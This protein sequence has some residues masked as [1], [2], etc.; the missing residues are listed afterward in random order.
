M[1]LTSA[2]LIAAKDRLRPILMTALTMI[3]VWC[4]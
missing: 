3:S 1:S 4:L 2:A